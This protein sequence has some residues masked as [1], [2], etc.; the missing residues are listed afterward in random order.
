MKILLAV[1][2]SPESDLAVKDVGARPW[3]PNTTVEVL[4]V[5]EPVYAPDVAS[6]TE[7]LNEKANQ[8][9]QTAAQR[10]RSSGIESPTTL[11]LS[12]N[13]KAAIVDHAAEICADLIV[14]GSHRSTTGRQFLRGS[15]ARGVVRFAP[16]SVEVA[17]VE[18]GPGPMKIL[19]A[20]DGS[21]YSEVAARSIAERPWPAGTTVR[22]LSVAEQ[23]IRLSKA[24]DRHRFD[25]EV[26]DR[27][28]KESIKRAKE[29]VKFAEKIIS[30][31]R[32][33]SASGTTAVSS[34]V[35][36]Q[37]ILNEARDWGANL[38]VVGSH[39]LRGI[40]RLLLGGVSEAIAMHALCSVEVIRHS[41]K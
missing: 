2:S 15:V 19:L 27:L 9:A 33:L 20:T 4:S 41:P 25:P 26:M 39:G 7:I 28:Q 5:V 16:C 17:R 10:L 40:T 29:A 30:E 21:H 6:L 24:V 32:L 14:V 36:K 8:V 34:A 31:G 23:P 13:P 22:V 1:D 18:T 37:L 11:V 35:P 3:P 12:G 38:I